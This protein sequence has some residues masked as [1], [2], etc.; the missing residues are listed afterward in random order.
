[1]YG[2]TQQ[3]KK[4]NKQLMKLTGLKKFAERNGDIATVKMT[5]KKWV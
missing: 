1:M 3:Y 5:T 2:E 4:R